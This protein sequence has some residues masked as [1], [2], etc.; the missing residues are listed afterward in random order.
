M[1]NKINTAMKNNYF[2]GIPLCIFSL[3]L[4]AQNVGINSTGGT[5]NSSS[6]LDM[7]T[8][9]TFTSPNGKGV[10][11]P[12]VALTGN[13]DATTIGT[14]NVTGMMIYNTATV[15]AVTSSTAVSPGYYYWN[16]AKW[17]SI[18]GGNG[19]MDWSLLGNAGTTGGTNYI[20]T[21]DAQSL[22][23]RTNATLRFRVPN[24][25]QVHAMS[26]GTNALPFYSFA[27]DPNTGMLSPS[28]DALTFSTGGIERFRMNSNGEV[29]TG[30]TAS[31]YAGDLL[32][33]YANAANPFGVNGYTDQNGSGTWGEVLLAGTT[34]FS[35][36]QG[37]YGG[38][39][40]GAGVLGNYNGTNVSNTRGGVVG[41]VSN[42]A[43]GGA[44]V[45][46]SHG[47]T[48]GNAHMG[49][50][51]TYNGSAFGI[52]AYGVGFGGGIIVGNNDIAVVGWRANNANYSGY[53]NGNHTIVNGT[54]SASVATSKGNQL[55]YCEESAEVWFSDMGNGQL[56][57][58][59]VTIQLDALF[60]E[61]VVIDQ[62]H[63][64]HVFIQ[65]EGESEDVYVIPGTTSF[66]VKER[67]GGTSNA[68]FSY[69]IYAKRVNFQDHRFGNDPVWGPG[70]T[71]QFAQY[72]PPP[73]VDYE[74]CVKFWAEQKK[75]WKP[76]PMPVGFIDYLTIQR[77]AKLFELTKHK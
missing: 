47:A 75:N 59:E 45:Y 37:V 32:V 50:L 39:G 69:K 42:V 29:I 77:E 44:A 5:P 74:E 56:S 9:N 72:A 7:N 49:T 15:G 31:P 76:T 52:G 1:K 25:D 68:R 65:M 71:R 10:I 6:I 34:N 67:N 13:T 53:F 46:G 62:N 61:T 19:G 2:F 60:L 23:F 58:G 26:L 40:S 12:N 20:G 30:N 11:F 54:K 57:N 73:P 3:S 14:G 33:G 28:A 43:T 27:A 17:V 51:G 8:G 4:S 48:S 21:S 55:L 64:M 41:T 22:D 38:S 63:P 18:N 24:A 16:G 70:D 66:V 36:V 35:A